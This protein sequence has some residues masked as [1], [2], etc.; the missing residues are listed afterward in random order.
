VFL[1]CANPRAGC[2]NAVADADDPGLTHGDEEDVVSD[3]NSRSSSS[4]RDDLVC[5]GLGAR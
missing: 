3:F 4:G 2:A 1:P 5:G